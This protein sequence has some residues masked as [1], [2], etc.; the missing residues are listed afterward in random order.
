MFQKD[1]AERIIAESN[2]KN[3]G[4]L[5]II[6]SWKLQIEKHFDVSKNCFFPKPKVESSVLSF[7]PKVN[8]IK[9][10][11]IF[12]QIF[13]Y[14]LEIRETLQNSAPYTHIHLAS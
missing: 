5:S 1:V 14:D 12:L 8:F 7:V 9:F 2:T 13:F 6:S 11:L 3:Y 4:R 10:N